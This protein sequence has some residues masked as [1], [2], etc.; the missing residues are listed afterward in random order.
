M[1][2]LISLCWHML[3]LPSSCAERI[4]QE[5]QLSLEVADLVLDIVQRLQHVTAAE[6]VPA[7]APAAP[8]AAAPAPTGRRTT[9]AAAAAAA[10]AAAQAGPSAAAA[11][12]APASGPDAYKAALTPHVVSG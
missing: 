2:K 11:A 5:A 6:D 9:R 1:I 3:L 12:A 4:K 8:P 7:A 10:A